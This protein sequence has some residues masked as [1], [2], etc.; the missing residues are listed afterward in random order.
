MHTYRSGRRQENDGD[1]PH[2]HCGPHVDDA[3]H[4]PVGVYTPPALPSRRRRRARMRDAPPPLRSA[5]VASALPARRGAAGLLLHSHVP[6]EVLLVPET[7]ERTKRTD[8]RTDGT[9]RRDARTNAGVFI[10]R[11]IRVTTLRRSSSHC[12]LRW[13]RVFFFRLLVCAP[14]ARRGI[15]ER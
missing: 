2:E 9:T 7:N 15:Y 13:T 11:G 5:H 6:R 1:R 12:A 8:R 3:S 14:R 10:P 4:I